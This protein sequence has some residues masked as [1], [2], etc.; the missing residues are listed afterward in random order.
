MRPFAAAWLLGLLAVPVT[1]P[2]Q[3]TCRPNI[4]GGQDCEGPEG[5]FS[6][7]PNIFG[8]FDTE[9]PG[10]AR[11]SSQPNV[12]DGEDIRTRGGIIQSQP[13]IFGGETYRLPDGGAR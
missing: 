13:N 2:G 7:R 10:K 1:A 5:R 3:V 12:F 11:S 6:S 4:F 9:G 8:G